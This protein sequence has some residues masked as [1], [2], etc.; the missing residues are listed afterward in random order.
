MKKLT[1]T[2]VAGIAL[3]TGCSK[4]EPIEIIQNETNQ[5]VLVVNQLDGTSTYETVSNDALYLN[6]DN[7]ND[8]KAGS[9]EA[10]TEGALIPA[11]KNAMTITW[12]GTHNANAIFGEAVM[13]Q[14]SPNSNF[15][16]GI[17]TECV[18]AEGNEAVYG[19]IITKAKGVYDG[20]ANVSE[21][22]RVYFKVTDGDKTKGG[23]DQISNTILFAAPKSGSLCNVYAPSD[24]IWTTLGAT[25]IEAPGYVIVKH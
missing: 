2:I 25:D 4:D 10:S 6:F 21:G 18:I 23:V 12:D 17:T 13:K 22:W 5:E 19:G 9:L 20:F 14:E 7:T 1:F 8:T 15:I 3:L 24:V 11:S 16:F